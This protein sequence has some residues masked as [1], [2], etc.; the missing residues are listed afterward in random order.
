[1]MPAMG[2]HPFGGV[3]VH[4][5]SNVLKPVGMNSGGYAL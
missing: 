4:P 3:V 2:P 5:S 1:M